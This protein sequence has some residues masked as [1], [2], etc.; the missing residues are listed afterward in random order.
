MVVVVLRAPRRRRTAAALAELVPRDPN[1]IL[2][3]KGAAPRLAA[4]L[5]KPDGGG[6]GAEEGAVAGSSS[7][8]AIPADV[9]WILFSLMVLAGGYWIAFGIYDNSARSY[10][11]REGFSE[12]ALFYIFAQVLERMAEFVAYVPLI[13]ARFKD[14]K[15]VTKADAGNEQATATAEGIEALTDGMDKVAASKATEVAKCK[16]D[17]DMIRSNRSVFFFCFNSAM[18][19]CAVAYFE[20]LI[21]EMAGVQGI[22]VETDIAVTALAIGGGTKPLHDLIKNIQKTKENKEDTTTVVAA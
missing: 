16:V 11:P 4:A 5:E 9:P 8:P 10:V 6:E 3:F 21:L 17:V 22:R 18:A 20:I 13:G 19:A 7:T 1:A 2:A 14:S 15:P 12:F